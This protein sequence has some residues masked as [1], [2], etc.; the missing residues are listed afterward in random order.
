MVDTD[1]A[2]FEE[3]AHRFFRAVSLRTL[4]AKFIPLIRNARRFA[5]VTCEKSISPKVSFRSSICSRNGPGGDRF[6]PPLVRC[7]CGVAE[8]EQHDQNNHD[9]ADDA[10]TATAVRPSPSDGRNSRRRRTAEE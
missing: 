3:L 8:Q 10:D 9:D 7:R 1:D 6:Q 2:L 4:L 5:G